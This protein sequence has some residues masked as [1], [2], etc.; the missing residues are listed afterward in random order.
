MGLGDDIKQVA[1]DVGGAVGGVAVDAAK[2]VAKTPLDILEEIL[3]GKAGDASGAKGDEAQK[4]VEKGADG[5][6]PTAD[7]AV[8]QQ[9]IQDDQKLTSQK[10]QMH[11]QNMATEQ[12]F[13][14]QKTTQAAQQKEVEKQQKKEQEK[15]EIKQIEKKKRE[16]YQVK[17]AQDAANAEKSRNV[18]AG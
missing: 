4:N 12:Q 3:G 18:G 10:L 1:T 16:N 5:Q 15:Y 13:F 8:I 6:S 11:R 14:D 9:K 7:P 17:A 2:T